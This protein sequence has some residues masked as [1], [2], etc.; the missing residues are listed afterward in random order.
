MSGRHA[1]G[2]RPRYKRGLTCRMRLSRPP[3]VREKCCMSD[4][5]DLARGWLAKGD[6]DLFSARLIAASSG[7][8]DTACFHARQAAEKYL[9]GLLALLAVLPQAAHP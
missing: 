2:P 7:P 8:Y 5:T 9:K 3:C 6:S 1:S 4:T